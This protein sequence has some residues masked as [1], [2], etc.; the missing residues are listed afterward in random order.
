MAV[1][2][3]DKIRDL[4]I[5][6]LLGETDRSPEGM[7][8]VAH[9]M[10]NRAD[11]NAWGDH[12]ISGLTRALTAPKQ[13]SM[14]NTDDPKLRALA[15]SV[16][17]ISTDDPRYQRAAAIADGVFGG[18]I[19]DPT[20]GATHYHTPSVNPDWSAGKTPVATIGGHYFYKLPLSAA[21]TAG[22]Y[23]PA[24]ITGPAMG[25]APLAPLGAAQPQAHA[26]IS[27]ALAAAR[28]M[29]GKNEVPDRAEIIKY[30]HDGGQDLDPHKLAWCASFVSATL[31]KAGLPVPTQVAKGSLVG[32]GANAR[33]YLTYGTAVDNPQ[34]IQA[35]DILVAKDG[36]HVGFA[37]GPV[38]QGANGPEVQLLAGNEKDTSGQYTPGSY[39][40]PETGA[41]ANRAQVGQV[42]ERWVPLSN[43]QVRRPG[44]AGDTIVS[45]G[46]PDVAAPAAQPVSATAPAGAS[47]IP[48][49]G[50]IPP[51]S[52]P[53]AGRGS[54]FVLQGILSGGGKTPITAGDWSGL[55]G[56]GATPVAAPPPA[57]S[58]ASPVTAT[59]S[60]TPMPLAPP[61]SP[62]EPEPPDFSKD[63]LINA[64]PS[65]GFPALVNPFGDQSASP[66]P[67]APAAPAPPAS[68]LPTFGSTAT[69]Y[70]DSETPEQMPGGGGRHP[71]F[72]PGQ[73]SLGFP[74]VTNPFGPVSQIP[75]SMLSS[76]QQLIKSLFG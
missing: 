72:T 8:S 64:H 26:A 75:G 63:S 22:T 43:Y 34:G 46:A 15:D 40:N 47:P 51:A 11:S 2:N 32:G 25:G 24:V 37:E 28:R 55:F 31:Q 9:V 71:A 27:D 76:A 68:T 7:I 18:Q 30:L 58:A 67:P 20:N 50:A 61:G 53:G 5:R 38:R 13:F 16:R 21:N 48:P 74:A 17:S 60:T 42:G 69:Y 12:T 70:D 52:S 45:G 6:T 65:M 39:T 66:T 29:L 19:P 14:W 73:P 1:W 54:G 3:N 10:K 35:G 4:V 41:V 62:L 44:A 59:Q 36:S 57:A 56:G 23:N 49:G 33:N